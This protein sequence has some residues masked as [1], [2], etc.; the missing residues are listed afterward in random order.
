MQREIMTHK[1]VLRYFPYMSERSCYYLIARVKKALNI[2]KGKY[3]YSDE[4]EEYYR[5]SK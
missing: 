5:L 4:F 1:L 3:L 2:P